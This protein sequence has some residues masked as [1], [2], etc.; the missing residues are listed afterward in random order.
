M[1]F[2]GILLLPGL[3]LPLLLLPG[4]C[5]CGFDC[6]DNDSNDGPAILTLGFSD[7]LPEDLKEVV[8]KVTA[9]TLRR[10]GGEDIVVDDFT[11]T[12][13]GREYVNVKDFQVNLLNY[14]GSEQLVVI[15]DLE[16]GAQ[17]YS[18][19]S[20]AIESGDNSNSYVKTDEDI[21][22]AL[23]VPGGSLDLGELRLASGAQAY[24]VEF[25]LAQA[26]EFQSS[27]ESY[28]LTTTG[29][30][31]ENNRTA[32]TL[33][34]QIDKTLFDSVPECREK[35]DPEK[36]NRIYLYPKNDLSID[37]LA[38]VFT[39]ASETT[40]PVTAAAPFAVASIRKDSFTGVWTYAFGHLPAGAYTMAF[41]CN[42]AEDD[43]VQ[44]DDLNIPLPTSQIYRIDLAESEPAVCN[45]TANA[46]C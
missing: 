7:S 44:W 33:S 13:G 24:T 19:V 17:R 29:I 3:L 45:L 34:G 23:S 32:A 43:S 37:N 46:R 8:I 41:S 11:L 27:P 36:G 12:I 21:Q 10:S 30:R 1:K 9:I 22:V 25:A 5:S 18:G 35:P 42:T 2:A 20:I 39:D 31:M 26:L 15:K 38:D 6:N 28:R 4:G 40:P 14:Q 16:I